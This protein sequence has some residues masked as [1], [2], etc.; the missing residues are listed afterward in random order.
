ME[1]GLPSILNLDYTT[2]NKP[3]RSKPEAQNCDLG[4]TT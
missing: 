4:I 1:P 3:L 2:L